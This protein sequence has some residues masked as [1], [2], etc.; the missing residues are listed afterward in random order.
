MPSISGHGDDVTHQLQTCKRSLAGLHED[1]L[2]C[3]RFPV[4][5]FDNNKFKKCIEH[6]K[7]W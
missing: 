3:D 1:S 7:I 6:G 5:F 2:L 4:V